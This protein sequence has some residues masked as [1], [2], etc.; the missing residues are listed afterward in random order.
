MSSLPREGPPIAGVPAPLDEILETP[1]EDVA[2]IV[3][4]AR[5]AQRGW[6]EESIVERIRTLARAK[7]SLLGAHE[8]IGALLR[9]ECGKPVAEAIFS[10]LVPTADVF[11]YWLASIEELVAPVEVELSR[12]AYPGKAARSYRGPRGVVGLVTPWNYPVAIPLRTI[13]PALLAGN[14]VVW[15]PS[16]HTSRVAKI[17]AA[18]FAKHLP[19]HVLSVVV[20]GA[21]QGEALVASKLDAVVFTGG[22]STGKKV[23]RACAETITLASVELGGKDA[24]VVLADARLERAAKGVV[25]GALTNA[26]QNCASIE[27]V[28]VVEKVAARFIDAVLA[29][30]AALAPDRD[31]GPLT[32]RAQ[33]VHVRAQIAEALERGAKLLTPPLAETND[34]RELAPV[35]L[36]IED[37]DVGILTEETFGPVLPIV[38]VATEEEAF[39]RV[40]RSRFALTTSIWT[41]AIDRLGPLVASLPTPIVTFNAHGLSGA[42]PEAPWSGARDSGFGV[43]NGPASLHCLTVPRFVLEDRSRGAEVYWYPYSKNLQEIA[44]AMVEVRGGASFFGRIAAL[45]SLVGAF[46][47][48]ALERSTPP[49]VRSAAVARKPPKPRGDAA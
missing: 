36:R 39:E 31:V 13:V 26:G 9:A 23:L 42:M 34:E 20:G 21:A 1:I 22:T 3:E 25:W 41:T 15:K 11:D 37:E 14:A 19:E 4:A 5:A 24:A 8:A 30:V 2:S 16:E 32:T 35:V 6:A 17:L 29:E 10:E 43:T 7:R 48:R 12:V 49:G 44:V 38:V 33:A 47:R 27:R 46:V 40:R 18:A 45:F 28:Y